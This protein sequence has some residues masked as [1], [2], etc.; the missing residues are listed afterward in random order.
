MRKKNKDEYDVDG[1]PP[2]P[3]Q[4]FIDEAVKMLRAKGV[5]ASDA[6][7]TTRVINAYR[8]KRAEVLGIKVK[9]K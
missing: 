5:K 2:V 7:L 4:A 1:L 3:S 6:E 8:V 9:L